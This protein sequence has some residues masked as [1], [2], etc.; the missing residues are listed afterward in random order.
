MAT[1]WVLESVTS[2]RTGAVTGPP[3]T[4][5]V[6]TAVVA[7]GPDV[8]RLPGRTPVLLSTSCCGGAGIAVILLLLL[9]LL[10][11]SG[12]SGGAGWPGRLCTGHSGRF[13]PTYLAARR[14]GDVVVVVD[15]RGLTATPSHNWN[16]LAKPRTDHG[17]C[18]RYHTN[19]TQLR[20]RH[21]EPK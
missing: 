1:V 15:G 2:S 12:L 20:Y 21:L 4:G 10:N 16:T 3:T 7:A 13:T 19:F 5:A 14:V 9:L 17:M 11:E 18:Y 6:V 8:C